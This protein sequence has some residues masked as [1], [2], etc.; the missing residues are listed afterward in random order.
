MIRE[1]HLPETILSQGKI[2][3]LLAHNLLYATLTDNIAC[4][5][6]TLVSL[7]FVISR[8]SICCQAT[9]KKAC[10]HLMDVS[11]L[12]NALSPHALFIHCPLTT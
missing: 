4:S 2:L 8:L 10:G 12:L 6:L 7:L 11:R 3:T 1:D 9:G 5:C